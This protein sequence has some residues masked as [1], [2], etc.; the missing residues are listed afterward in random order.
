[1]GTGPLSLTE[2]S[3]YRGRL[4]PTPTGLLHLGH[5]RTFW[6]AFERARQ[7]GGTLLLRIEDLDPDRCR[8]EFTT[9]VF[10]DLGWL[11]L[12]WQ[13]GPDVGGPCE[14]YVQ[15]QRRPYYLEIW[16]RLYAA[17]A[18]YPSPHSRKD[19]D[20]ALLAPHEGPKR[21]AGENDL[22]GEE[23]ADREPIF[24]V[25]LRPT[26]MPRPGEWIEPGSVNWRFRVP[27]REA[28]QFRDGRV[29]ETCRVAGV[30][31]G[32]FLVWRRDGSPSYELA[33]VADDHAMRISEVVR[34]EDL[35]TSTARQLLLYRALGWKPP[36]FFH[37][38][39]ML[40]AAG[41]RLA[42]RSGSVAL[43]TLRADGQSPEE[44][45]AGWGRLS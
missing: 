15:S 45:R 30:E 34:G 7:A 18:I 33:V 1:M 8:S 22:S 16:R 5:A 12:R 37:C 13:E 44:L 32:D 40:D 28:I 42:K 3:H 23:A 21:I 41:R 31:F 43:R 38:P 11:G 6:A 26:A 9:A 25:S 14:P 2:S 24:P 35:L 20:L 29:G 17:G 10:E 4:A 27:D 39:L 19:V 36:E